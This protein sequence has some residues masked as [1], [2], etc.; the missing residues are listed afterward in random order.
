M[1][2]TPGAGLE[3]ARVCHG[4]PC[5]A[6]AHLYE[7]RTAM[8][9]NAFDP[10][11]YRTTSGYTQGTDLTGYKIAALDGDIGKVDEANDQTG[12]SS[13]VVDTGPWIFGRKVLLPAGVVEKVDHDDKKVYVDRTKDQIK[14]APEYNSDAGVDDDYRTRLG[15]YYDDTYRSGM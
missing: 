14:D 6:N 2:E 1:L 5:W 7:R 15:G 9:M 4:F 10:W 12:T 11:N 3:L 13:L 8:S